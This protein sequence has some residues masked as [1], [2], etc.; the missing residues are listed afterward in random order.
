M[1]E[2][3]GGRRGEKVEC[4][5][6]NPN[7]DPDEDEDGSGGPS[8]ATRGEDTSEEVESCRE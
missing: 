1:R 2:E 3:E 4:C 8:E 6:P 7:P 5:S